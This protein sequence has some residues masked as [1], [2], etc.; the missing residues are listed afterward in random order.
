MAG[1][2]LASGTRVVVVL[3]TDGLPTTVMVDSKQRGG[4][5]DKH[6]LIRAL[7]SLESSFPVWIVVRLCTNDKKVVDFYNAL[8]QE[9]KLNLEVLDDYPQ[10]AKEIYKTNPWLTYGLPLHRCRE[11]GFHHRII[12][13]LDE[14]KL[15]KDEV[16]DCCR[17]LF[18]AEK[19]NNRLL[20]D[21]A[22]DWKGFL[23]ELK[24]LLQQEP[25]QFNPI[26]RRMTPW[27]DVNRLRREY[28]SSKGGCNI[29]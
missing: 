29:M 17:F 3:A 24:Q 12:D 23:K 7:R 14:R 16:K 18:G 8:D 26:K 28:S 15:T 19:T 25:L 2:L 4:T 20:A 22:T 1:S 21:P 10:E 11:M 13:M 5:V 6:D 27:I 9:L